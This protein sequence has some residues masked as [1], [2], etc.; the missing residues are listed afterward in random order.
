MTL[1]NKQHDECL[2]PPALIAYASVVRDNIR[3]LA[4][5]GRWV[6]IRIRPD[7]KTHKLRWIARMQLKSGAVDLTVARVGEAEVIS[8]AGADIFRAYPPLRRSRAERVA[9]R[10][11]DRTMRAAVDSFIAID[12]VPAAASAAHTTVGLVVD[13]DVCLGRTGV[14]HLVING[15]SNWC[16]MCLGDA[17]RHG[18]NVLG[19]RN[20]RLVP[21]WKWK[22]SCV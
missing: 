21:L 7:T 6:G 3:K 12:E 20:C 18:R 15:A 11:R 19:W 9:K 13:I 8:D 16:S 17:S 1:A 22:K 14:Q 10:A 2:A 5:Y 4:D